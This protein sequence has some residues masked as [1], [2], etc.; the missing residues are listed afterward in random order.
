MQDVTGTAGREIIETLQEKRQA[1]DYYVII[2]PYYGK[3]M[4]NSYQKLR[5]Y[6]DGR[7]ADPNYHKIPH[8]PIWIEAL[9]VFLLF[10]G[11]CECVNKSL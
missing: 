2:S 11:V 9:K 7:I 3:N 5:E 8:Y 4:R 10:M 6:T 1:E